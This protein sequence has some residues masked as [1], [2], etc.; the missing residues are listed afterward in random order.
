ML[1]CSSEVTLPSMYG[2]ELFSGTLGSYSYQMWFIYVRNCII[3]I[4]I[5]YRLW[6]FYSFPAYEDKNFETHNIRIRFCLLT[7]L[8][9]YQDSAMSFMKKKS[10]SILKICQSLFGGKK[11]EG[12]IHI[13]RK[14]TFRLFEH[15][16]PLRSHI[17]S[18]ESKQKDTFSNPPY[19]SAV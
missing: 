6:S 3:C 7:C 10:L 19:H 14:H 18:S 4:L 12:I 13:L 9:R 2:R 17:Y 15:P 16:F 1:S 5:C 8:N 11:G